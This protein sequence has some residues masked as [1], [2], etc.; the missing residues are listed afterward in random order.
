LILHQPPAIVNPPR[1]AQIPGE[2]APFIRELR[3]L[4]EEGLLS[5]QRLHS[6]NSRNSRIPL[7]SILSRSICLY[8]FA[9]NDFAKHTAIS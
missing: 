2:K 6:R 9:L 7:S 4:R 5:C 1:Q 3:E 8:D